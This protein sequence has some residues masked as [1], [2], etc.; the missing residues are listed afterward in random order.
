MIREQL[1]SPILY[2]RQKA[3]RRKAGYLAGPPIIAVGLQAP[4]NIGAVLRLADAAG[5]KR[6]IFVNCENTLQDRKRIQRTARNGDAFVEWEC[7]SLSDL[8]AGAALYQ[9]LIALELTND[10]TSIFATQLP[11]P[12]SVV[13]GNESHGIPATLLLRCQTAV[14]IPM[15]GV[16]G[17]MN[18]THALAIALFEWRR[19]HSD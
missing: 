2:E 19:Q 13:I 3:F 10:S 6:V 18:V 1:G 4:E 7:Q 11:A 16:N 5:S 12:C 15:Y 14:H 8:I 17:S 9:P